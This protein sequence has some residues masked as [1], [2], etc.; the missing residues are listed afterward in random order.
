[1]K[2]FI[3]SKWIAAFVA[4]VLVALF[5]GAG[6][7]IGFNSNFDLTASKVTH[8][9]TTSEVDTLIWNREGSVSAL[10][11]AAHF[12]DSVSVTSVIVRRVIDG[13]VQAV[14]AGDTLT[15]FNSFV[16]TSNTGSAV[17]AAVTLAPLADQYWFIITYAG[18]AQGFTSAT[19]VY[20]GIKQYSRR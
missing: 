8:S 1:M 10:A 11:F 20:E 3:S 15:P 2:R 5:L 12:K 18:S 17:T 4:V 6:S 14:I 7:Q 13:Q 16:S 9:Y 19:A